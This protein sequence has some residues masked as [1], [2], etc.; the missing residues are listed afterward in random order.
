MKY[1]YSINRSQDEI[2]FDPHIHGGLTY[3]SPENQV[4]FMDTVNK[5]SERA[6]KI[7]EII[8]SPPPPELIKRVNDGVELSKWTLVLYLFYDLGWRENHIKVAMKELKQAFSR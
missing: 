5:L 6:R 4:I 2:E 1:E 3:D 7:V 8:F